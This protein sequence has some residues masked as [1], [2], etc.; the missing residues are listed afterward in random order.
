MSTTSTLW[1]YIIITAV[2]TF[3]SVFADKQV[4]GFGKRFISPAVF[5]T[6]S[7]FIHWIFYCFTDIGADY[8]NY[9]ELISTITLRRHPGLEIGSTFLFVV[10]R[11]IFKSPDIVIFIYK[12]IFLIIFYRCFSMIKEKQYV[13]I[14]M[15]AFNVLLYLNLFVVIRMTGAIAL[16]TVS[17]IYLMNNKNLKS[18]IFLVLASLIHYTAIFMAPA[19]IVYYLVRR[20]EHKVRIG[21][22]FIATLIVLLVMSRYA[23]IYSFLMKNI[24]WLSENKG[25]G[26]TETYSGS[27]IVAYLIIIPLSVFAIEIYFYSEDITL[28]NISSI[29]TIYCVFWILMGYRVNVLARMNYYSYFISG[30]CIPRYL[31]EKSISRRGR[32]N[33]NIGVF[34]FICFLIFRYYLILHDISDVSSQA[35]MSNYSF[36]WPF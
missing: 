23:S 21:I 20:N 24:S 26:L 17:I 34:I 5:L 33:A 3:L 4:I 16:F 19:Y 32:F 27:G 30:V 9:R 13:W 28:I 29:F 1:L 7:F 14:A 10:L 25:Y 8:Y 22:V 12:T 36:F 15:F 18:I 31:K 2:T 11:S 35:L 6:I